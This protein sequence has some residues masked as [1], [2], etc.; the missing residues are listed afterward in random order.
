MDHPTTKRPRLDSVS[1]PYNA[2]TFAHPPPPHAPSSRPAS[3]SAPTHASHSAPTHASP[4]PPRHYPPHCLPPPPGQA[5]YHS[6][7]LPPSDIRSFADPRTIPSPSHR[8]NGLPGPPVTVG[9]D[10][11][12]TYRPPP[13]PQSTSAPEPQGSRANSITVDVKPSPGMEHG[14]HQSPWSMTTDHRSNG[15]MS[16]GYN[17]AISPTHP[18]DQAFHPPP[19]PPGQYGQ[20]VQYPAAPSP[21]MGQ[22]ASQAQSA[23]MRRKQVRATQACNHCRSRKQKCDEARPCQFCRE[24]NFDCQYKDVPPPKCGSMSK[25]IALS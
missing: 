17:S 9:Q 3:H 11:I 14:G 21:Y 22:Y 7:S 18:T 19:P 15:S 8:P 1:P 5:L 13:H 25:R 23:Q 24:N 4:P 20:P 10:S 6:P 12:S 16:N 2:H